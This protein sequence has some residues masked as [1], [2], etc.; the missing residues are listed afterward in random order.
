MIIGFSIYSGLIDHKSSYMKSCKISV[1]KR[2][3]E[4]A[5]RATPHDIRWRCE[6]L[7]KDTDSWN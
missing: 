2:F 4:N 3:K 5:N 6:Q 7:F 1:A